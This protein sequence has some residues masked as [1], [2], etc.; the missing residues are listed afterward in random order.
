MLTAVPLGITLTLMMVLLYLPGTLRVGRDGLAASWL[1]WTT[2]YP[3]SDIETITPKLMPSEVL[4]LRRLHSHVLLTRRDGSNVHIPYR[5]PHRDSDDA[6]FEDLLE[7]LRGHHNA[8][9]RHLGLYEGALKE[10]EGIPLA[11]LGAAHSGAPHR[12]PAFDVDYL[13]ELALAGA[14]TSDVRARAA[15]LIARSPEAGAHVLASIRQEVADPAFDALLRA[16]AGESSTSVEKSFRRLV[17]ST[18]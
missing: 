7:E 6:D 15:V 1:G 9:K 16:L 14:A 12:L 10:Y 5:S 3:F 13:R 2:F 4:K 11:E 17:R 18:T 8:C